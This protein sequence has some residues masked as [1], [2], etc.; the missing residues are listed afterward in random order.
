MAI[1]QII[2]SIG[3]DSSIYL[4]IGERTALID[5]GTGLDSVNV[6]SQIR[7]LLGGKRLDMIILTHCHV[8]HIGGLYDIQNSFDSC[9]YAGKDAV[10]I[11][12]GDPHVTLCDMFGVKLK[13]VQVEEVPDRMILDLGGHKLETIYTPGHTS[14]GI[15]IYDWETGSLFSGDTLF[16][17][18]VGRCDFPTGSDAD[19]IDSVKMISKLNIKSLHPGHGRSVVDGSRMAEYALKMM[20]VWN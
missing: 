5:T 17:N 2:S 18:G 3:F 14:G 12:S 9:A 7:T 11:R 6:V 19:L 13:P 8:D 10:A 1:H 20:G 4:I 15:S 16:E